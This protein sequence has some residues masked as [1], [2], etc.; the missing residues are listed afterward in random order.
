MIHM[1]KNTAKRF[2]SKTGKYKIVPNSSQ[3]RNYKTA[4]LQISV[5]RR[6]CF[7][8]R[9]QALME[10][11]T[12]NFETVTLCVHDTIQLYNFMADGA[13]KEEAYKIALENGNVF[14]KEN[15]LPL[16]VFIDVVRWDEITSN[17]QY[18]LVHQR[19][20]DLYKKDSSFAKSIDDDVQT[21]ANRCMKRGEDFPSHRFDLSK[22]LLLEEI[23][24]YVI[25]NQ[26]TSAA[27]LHA[28]MRMKAMQ[29][30]LD[31]TGGFNLKDN[32]MITIGM[33]DREK[34]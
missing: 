9:V 29:L 15:T 32:A 25:L 21:F 26:E 23:S 1:A 22:A 33:Y 14:L 12:D 7:D 4:R 28:G 17:K 27:D 19:V 16:N 6:P 20:I 8:G 13:S 18:N 5:P 11:A 31:G 34:T 24:G 3:W 2:Y 30:L 10:W